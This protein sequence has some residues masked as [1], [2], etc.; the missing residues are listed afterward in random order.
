MFTRALQSDRFTVMVGPCKEVFEVSQDL[1][2]QCSPFFE[3]SCSL[4][5]KECIEQV[6]NLP[7]DNPLIFEGLF[8]L[9][10]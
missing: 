5:F 1:L 7:E 9:A 3:K 4:P 10:P 6:I 2:I 8:N